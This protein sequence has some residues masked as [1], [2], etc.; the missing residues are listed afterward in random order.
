[1][2]RRKGEKREKEREGVR[3]IIGGDFNARTEELGDEITSKD[4]KE[5][6]EGRKLKDK[7]G[8]KD[9][10]KQDRSSGM[11]NLE[12]RYSRR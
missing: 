2:V 7:R 4:K 3:T 8:S 9:F 6:E 5:G 12:W 11:G 10:I 1:M